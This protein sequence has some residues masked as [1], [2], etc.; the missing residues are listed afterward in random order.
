MESEGISAP[1]LERCDEGVEVVGR[2]EAVWV[3]VG[4]TN[5][6]AGVP[7]STRLGASSVFFGDRW[8][9]GT[10]EAQSWFLGSTSGI[11]CATGWDLMRKAV[12]P[13]QLAARTAPARPRRRSP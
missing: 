5:L 12:Y 3:E 7:P 1:G 6:N 9:I 2:H 4:R 10:E 13:R 11:P 8:L